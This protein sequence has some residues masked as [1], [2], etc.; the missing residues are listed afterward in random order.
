MDGAT[1]NYAKDLGIHIILGGTAKTS[2]LCLII[3]NKKNV[4]F[5][6]YEKKFKEALERAKVAHKDEDRHLKATLERIFPELK[7]SE[8]EKM[9]KSIIYALRNGG[10]YSKDKT[11]EA[12]AWLE[13]QKD[14][15]DREYVFRPLAGDTIEKA[16]GKAVE[17]DGK[18]V[19]AFNGAYIP[20]GN[21]TKDEIVAEYHDLVKKQCDRVKL[22]DSSYTTDNN[23]YKD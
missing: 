14:A 3:N 1:Q 18:V 13:K 23:T 20:V 17:L 8:D 9:R 19:L 16:A 15:C 10:F 21:K 4:T 7:E 5:M 12:I 2:I 6:E 11:D 22:P